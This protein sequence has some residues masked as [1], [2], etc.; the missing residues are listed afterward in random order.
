MRRVYHPGADDGRVVVLDGHTFDSWVLVQDL[1]GCAWV[2]KVCANF[3]ERRGDYQTSGTT[4]RL[5][6]WELCRFLATLVERLFNGEVLLG[7]TVVTRWPGLHVWDVTNKSNPNIP[8]AASD[9]NVEIQ[10]KCDSHC[11]EKIA[12]KCCTSRFCALMDQWETA[13]CVDIF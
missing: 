11:V 10:N 4:L 7:Y 6:I 9:W 12:K 13:K 2:L 5:N 3:V 1:N 8:N